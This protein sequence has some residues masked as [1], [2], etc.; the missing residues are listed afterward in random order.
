MALFYTK[1]GFCVVSFYASK[2]MLVECFMSQ[3]WNMSVLSLQ[4]QQS[5]SMELF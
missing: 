4:Q 5:L 1:F 2:N 3:L